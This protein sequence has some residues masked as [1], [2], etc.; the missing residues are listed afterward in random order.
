[1]SRTTPIKDTI[2]PVPKLPKHCVIYQIPASPFWW[3]R[4]FTPSKRY[5]V[6]S[7]KTTDK[8]IA[9]GVARQMFYDSLTTSAP[10]AGVTPKTFKAVALSLLED[11]RASAKRS[12][13]IN[14][15]SR[16]NTLI[17]D[18]FGSKLLQDVSHQ[19]LTAFVAKLRDRDLAPATKK[20]YVSLVKKVFRHGVSLG[21]IDRMPVFPKLGE[22]LRTAQVR[23]Y[24]TW[25]EYQ[26]LSQTVM[27]LEKDG[28][29]YRGTPITS[30]F[31]LL[32]NFMINSFIRPSDLRVLKHKHVQR[33]HDGA[34]KTRWLTLRH[35]AT[36]TT[37]EP[38]QAMPACVEHYDDLI[39]FRKRQKAIGRA[40]SDY[41]SPD[42]YLFMPQFANRSTAME[43]LGKIFGQI[44]KASGLR[45]TTGKN[46]TLYSLRHT[47]IMYRLEKSDAD[48]LALA[49]NARTS[50]AVIE[51]FYGAHLTTEKARIRLHS[52]TQGH[53]HR[54]RGEAQHK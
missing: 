43:K 17:F 38:V 52:F 51:K 15:E 8:R 4:C 50:Q 26:K 54:K 37:A 39:A 44:V 47:A 41:L 1:M 28:A 11:E 21:A 30:E 10:P 53:P 5:K 7:T 14:D 24:L 16:F 18:H 34:T 48:T 22:P 36:K 19:D 29:E 6:K 49:K 12:L 3:A 27:K 31:K 35:P 33:R 42:D 2:T 40:S 25:R 9:F 13:L 32:A 20:H 45:E 46:I 23:D